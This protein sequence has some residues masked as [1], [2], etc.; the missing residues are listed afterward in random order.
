MQTKAIFILII[1]EI[2]EPGIPI[3]TLTSRISKC[4]INILKF[5]IRMF[6]YLE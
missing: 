3:W 5:G 6:L 4:F 1:I 2:I